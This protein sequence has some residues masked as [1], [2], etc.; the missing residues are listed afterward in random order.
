M[1]L[2]ALLATALVALIPTRRLFVGGRSTMVTAGYFVIL[3]LLGL[4]VALGPGRGRLFLP[5]VLVLY[6][7]PFITWRAGVARLLGRP[8]PPR[9]V[10]PPSEA[11]PPGIR[12]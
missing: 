4:L 1:L 7:L 3:W 12:S 6:V 11:D 9:N 8:A 5:V 2:A 10:T